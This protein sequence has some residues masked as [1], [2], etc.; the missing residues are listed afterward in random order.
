MTSRPMA[1]M[2]LVLLLFVC[3]IG[4]KIEKGLRNGGQADVV[5]ARR[6][7]IIEGALP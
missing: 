4:T 5:R 1:V 6:K 2:M 3:K 7:L